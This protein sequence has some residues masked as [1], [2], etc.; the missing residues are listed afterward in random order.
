MNYLPVELHCHTIH[1]DGDFTPESLQK[2][3]VENGLSLI[4]L[5]DHNTFSGTEELKS[6][7][8][9]FIKGIEWTTY[10]GHMLVLGAKSFVDWRDAVPDNIDEKI[11]A[12]KAAGGTVGVAHPYQCGSPICTGGRW[13]FNVKKWEN[14]DYIEIWHE[15]F[16]EKNTENDRAAAMWTGLLDK[17]YRLAASYGRDWHRPNKQTDVLGCTYLGF[18]GEVCQN[19]AIEAIKNGR[20]V[21]SV[22]AKFAFTV[23]QGEKVYD[24]GDTVPSGI[25]KFNFITDLSAREQYSPNKE[26]KYKSIKIVTNGGNTELEIPAGQISSEIELQSGH[27]YRAELWGTIDGKE[28]PLAITSP[29]YIE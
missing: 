1:S 21:V 17:G 15:A 19:T 25:A 22:G 20:T 27:W 23:S 13:E 4:A 3:A 10:F 18:D 6:D 8:C 11:S 7:I 12:V 14:V 2:A 5:T 28:F 16:S 29:I 26:I 24:I 9:P